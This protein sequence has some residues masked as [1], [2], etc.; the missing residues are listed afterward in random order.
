MNYRSQ[1]TSMWFDHRIVL[2]DSPIHGTGTFAIDDISAGEPLILVTG[3]LVLT[4]EDWDTGRIQING[5]LYNEER[6]ADNITIVTPVSFH[7]YINH[8]CAPNAIDL[9]RYPSAIQYVAA[10][11][12]RAGEELTADY[13]TQETLEHCL[14]GTLEC[15]WRIHVDES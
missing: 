14:C 1:P 9:S 15:R 3:G 12:I 2:R 10:R 11:D 13:Y 8:S 6:L 7:Y 5:M 4:K